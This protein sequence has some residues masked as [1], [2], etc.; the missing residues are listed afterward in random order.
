MLRRGDSR[1][2]F[3]EA[4]AL[5]ELR[6]KMRRQLGEG[7]REVASELEHE[8]IEEDWLQAF[9]FQ[10]RH[11]KLNVRRLAR[12]DLMQ[13]V[14]KVD[15]GALQE[16]LENIAFCNL[17]VGDLQGL[18]DQNIVK[19][20]RVA[21]LI[22][23][24]LL[25]LENALFAQVDAA[26]ADARDASA[27][28]NQLAEDNGVLADEN[29]RLRKEIRQKRKALATFEYVLTVH[30]PGGASMKETL[31]KA[32]AGTR[33]GAGLDAPGLEASVCG[34]CGKTFSSREFLR[35]HCARRK[36]TFMPEEAENLEPNRANEASTEDA[37]EKM[38]QALLAAVKERESAV[39]EAI[40]ET[41][42]SERKMHIEQL[43]TLKADRRAHEERVEAQYEARLS[44][45]QLGYEQRI[46]GLEAK[47][48]VF[49]T[50]QWTAREREDEEAATRRAEARK[51]QE[52]QQNRLAM[53]ERELQHHRAQQLERAASDSSSAAL[54]RSSSPS[55]VSSSSSSRSSASHRDRQDDADF[56]TQRF[57]AA[58]VANFCRSL[59]SLVR[60]HNKIRSGRA[61]A[62]LQVHA[63]DAS[64]VQAKRDLVQSIS[65]QEALSQEAP[66]SP[67]QAVARHVANM[68]GPD[69][70]EAKPIHEALV[71][72]IALQY[73]HAQREDTIT[74]AERDAMAEAE[75]VIDGKAAI[76]SSRFK[77][78]TQ[79]MDH[80]P[81]PEKPHVRSR[82]DH[83][84]AEIHAQ[85]DEARRQLYTRM[86]RFDASLPEL[87]VLDDEQRVHLQRQIEVARRNQPQGG[88][89]K[90]LRAVQKLT[91][92]LTDAFYKPPA[93]EDLQ[94]YEDEFPQ[95][96]DI[97]LRDAMVPISERHK[98]QPR[99][100]PPVVQQPS[101]LQLQVDQPFASISSSSSSSSPSPSL[102]DEAKTS[103]P[104]SAEDESEDESEDDGTSRAIASWA[105]KSH[106]GRSEDDA[107]QGQ[108]DEDGLWAV[109]RV[110]TTRDFGAT[111]DFGTEP[112]TT[113]T[114]AEEE[115][116]SSEPS[117][118]PLPPKPQTAR[119]PRPRNLTSKPQQNLRPLES[120][121]LEQV[122]V[123]TAN[124]SMQVFQSQRDV[125]GDAQQVATNA[126]SQDLCATE[127]DA[128]VSPENSSCSIA[129]EEKVMMHQG[130]DGKQQASDRDYL[131]VG[132]DFASATMRAQNVVI[133]DDDNDN[134]TA[135]D[136]DGFAVEKQA[137]SKED[138]TEEEVE[139]HS[140]IDGK[141]AS[142]GEGKKDKELDEK[143]EKRDLGAKEE[144]RF[145]DE[146][147]AQE[148]DFSSD[149][150][151][152]FAAQAS[153]QAVVAISE[154][155]ASDL[156][157]MRWD[158]VIESSSTSQPSASAPAAAHADDDH[159]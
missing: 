155:G 76:L 46:A 130:K 42:A 99:E 132:A 125:S 144:Q 64:L 83:S 159:K 145:A 10:Q 91:S 59:A 70:L 84:A 107:M 50:L 111:R 156:A 2:G 68:V 113:S 52:E 116:D 5:H 62:R 134:D 20:F 40:E 27:D 74:E 6:S 141:D 23:E 106:Q 8:E 85:L 24:Y 72:Q 146:S 35:R 67:K 105:A 53:L 12:L 47:L 22:I 136:K 123:S 119:V 78:G 11:G 49:R 149:E 120:A 148:Q 4:E 75:T 88:F 118:L 16:M 122:E 95:P 101:F 37:L 61:F 21:Q 58:I 36:H 69:E 31:A 60:N 87:D 51:L 25:N 151:L 38:Q 94:A 109:N 57:R 89:T 33:A 142:V 80:A 110:Q 44:T 43:E 55:V 140:L 121:Q 29:D 30:G 108:G 128:N 126:T 129:S 96:R 114:Q 1:E 137:Q 15:V 152:S 104:Q 45:Q 86:A 73:L 63:R 93:A 131:T 138:E 133:R 97:L 34:T 135:E 71:Q 39:R 150:S 102:R 143:E 48:E 19:A 81:L 115:S 65:E 127:E 14:E 82:W 7:E 90:A 92:N 124:E 54:S 112:E 9:T 66:A 18:S 147:E 117:P 139:A 17:K 153:S 157:A 32:L 77:V 28:A 154:V 100:R 79:S 103:S 158:F 56:A 26:R 98:A 41:R 13:I 3:A